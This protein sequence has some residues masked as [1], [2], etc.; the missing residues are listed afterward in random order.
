ME[1]GYVSNRGGSVLTI[2]NPDMHPYGS[3]DKY[4]IE[5]PKIGESRCHSGVHHSF[6]NS[7]QKSVGVVSKKVVMGDQSTGHLAS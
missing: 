1:V 5:E 4:E 7:C 2:F 6:W 3:D